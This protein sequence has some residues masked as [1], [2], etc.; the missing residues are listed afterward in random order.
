MLLSSP[1]QIMEAIESGQ[2]TIVHWWAP[3]IGQESPFQYMFEEHADRSDSV[4]FYIVDSGF[5]H[6]QHSP[7]EMPLTVFYIDGD[8]VDSAPFDPDAIDELLSKL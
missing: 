6:P 3:W 8:E 1:G 7:D 5:I 2:P 4:A